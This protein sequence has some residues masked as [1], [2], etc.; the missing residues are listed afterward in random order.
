MIKTL[1]LPR[2]AA[3][4]AFVTATA[5]FAQNA[6]TLRQGNVEIGGFVGGGYGLNITGGENGSSF[7]ESATNFH[8]MGGGDAGYAITKSVFLVGEVSYFP[9]LSPATS[10]STVCA[11]GVSPP[12]T[13][14]SPCYDRELSFD[15]RVFEF[16]G[17]IHYRLPVPE[18]RVVPYL[19][20]GVGAAHFMGTT[21]TNELVQLTGCS[22]SACITPGASQSVSGQTAFEIAGGAGLRVYMT[23]HFGFRGEFQIYHPFGIANLGSFYRVS[24]GVF[25][26][27]K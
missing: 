8:V 19:V 25:F 3:L 20:G 24:G 1:G 6:P 10:M 17:G 18:S 14:S 2:F 26:E 9:S 4:F 5:S 7:S 21:V 27:L 15:R 22:G 11:P 23:E 16:N 13:T 12:G